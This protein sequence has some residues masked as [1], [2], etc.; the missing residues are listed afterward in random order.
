MGKILLFYKYVDINNPNLM[1]DWQRELCQQLHLKGRIFIAQEGINATVGGSEA[2]IGTYLK[3]MSEHPLFHDID[4]KESPGSEDYFPR[5]QVTVKKEIVRLGLDSELINA[6]NGGKHLTPEQAHQLIAQ[7]P[8]N[9]VILDG[10]NNYESRIG[11]FQDA[12]TP[13]I[14]TFKEFPE[15]IDNNLEQFK[16]KQVLMFCTGG[17]RC[18]RA[19]AYLK[20]KQ[21]TQEVYQISGGIH[22]YIEQFPDGYF[23]GKNYV[24]DGRI[25][26][27][28][29]DDIL[30][31]CFVCNKTYDEYTNCINA[32]CNK[33]IIVCDS[34]V[35][36]YHNTCSAICLELVKAGKVK[37]RKI[38]AKVTL[39]LDHAS[40]ML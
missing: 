21:V 23:R 5:L 7:K 3:A 2:N 19:S 29:N 12:I 15:Y 35:V 17:I 16:D 13:D 6:K 24:F 10:R 8:E 40:C 1:A 25:A 39:P 37:I 11:T 27:K 22:R 9:L 26:V 18:E 28:V 38:A 34:C 30:A 32:E 31:N 33:Q 36:D 14:D 4:Y 20:S